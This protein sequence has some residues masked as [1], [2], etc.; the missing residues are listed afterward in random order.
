ME[1]TFCQHL[2]PGET[3]SSCSRV[4]IKEIVCKGNKIKV[5]NRHYRI[6]KGLK[7]GEKENKDGNRNQ[8]LTR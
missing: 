7:V 8:A 3:R 2:R 1:I 4:G 5:C 6:H